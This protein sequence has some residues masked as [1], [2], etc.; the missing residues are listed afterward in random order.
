MHGPGKGGGAEPWLQHPP[1]PQQACVQ[2]ETGPVPLQPAAYAAAARINADAWRDAPQITGYTSQDFFSYAGKESFNPKLL[3]TVDHLNA[4]L[5]FA[6]EG[7]TSQGQPN[8]PKKV[9]RQKEA[10]G[11]YR[12]L[13]AARLVNIYTTESFCSCSASNLYVCSKTGAI[14]LT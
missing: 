6:V 8:G 2:M 3:G 4:S 14:M 10:S 7:T 9:P 13:V 11:R 12:W 1:H 5:L